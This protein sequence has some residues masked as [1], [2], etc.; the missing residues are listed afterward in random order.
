M[1][2]VADVAAFLDR[3]AP[4]SHAASWDNVGLLVGDS[5][6]PVGRVMT[7]LTVTADVIA[8]A[9]AEDVKLIVSHHPVLFRGAKRLTTHTTDGRL[10]WM[11]KKKL[12]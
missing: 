1:P 11:T 12:V 4:P 9:L 6:A 2:T 10:L 8:E 3:F 7:C 5:N